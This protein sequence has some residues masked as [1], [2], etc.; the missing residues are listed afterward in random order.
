MIEIKEKYKWSKESLKWN[1]IT[2]PDNESQAFSIVDCKNIQN[3]DNNLTNLI[4]VCSGFRIENLSKDNIFINDNI[5]EISTV[6]NYYQNSAKNILIKLLLLDKEAPLLEQSKL[7]AKYIDIMSN[8][9]NI[10]SINIIGYSKCGC[11]ALYLPKYFKNPT[12]FIKT[13]IYSIAAPFL[14]T[15]IA[16]P[17]ALF[18]ELERVIK[19]TLGDNLLSQKVFL[20]IKK[21][22]L[23]YISMSHMDNDISIPG[24]LYENML[25]EY[26]PNF[27]ANV[28]QAENVSAIQ[29]VKTFAN[30]YTGIND[31]TL[32]EAIKT[33]NYGGIGL[34]IINDK[35]FDKK[36][37]GVVPLASQKAFDVYCPNQQT[38]TLN[39]AHHAI[40]SNK[41]V[42]NDLL[43]ILDNKIDENNYSKV[44]KR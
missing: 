20:S 1:K 10:S 15:I 33:Q 5:N 34:C 6:S 38:Y 43:T 18:I 16:S 28:F 8:Y 19:S 7:L 12:S 44:L 31:K 40:F 42:F 24:G 29:K 4:I 30:I 23:K 35:L 41:R 39:G 36:S 13:N 22:Y 3:N 32:K 27:L 26:D 21:I 37:D 25:N 11:M 17:K 9:N 2:Q 14:G